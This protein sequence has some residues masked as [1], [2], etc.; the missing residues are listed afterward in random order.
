[1]KLRLL[2]LTLFAITSLQSYLAHAQKTQAQFQSQLTTHAERSQYKET[3]RYAEVISLCKQYQT[4]YPN[5][6]NCIQFGTTPEGRPMMALIAS[7]TGVLNAEQAKQ[8]KLPVVLIQGGIHAG[9]IDGK[10]AIF[11]AL[12]DTLEN[13]AAQGALEK[14]VVIFVPVFNVDGHER[15]GPWNRPNQRGPEQMGWRTTA[16]NFN[17]NRDYVKADAPEMQAMLKLVNT[18]D[19]L[20]VIDL[21]VTD[22]AKFEHDISIQVEPAIAGPEQIRQ[23]GQHLRDAVIADL[24]QQGSL[25][26]HFYMSFI[27]E[28]NPMSGFAD[29]VSTP[30][31]STGYFQLRNRLGMLVETHSWK[32]Y[33]TRVRITRNTIISVL[34]QLARHGKR[35]REVVLDQD[36]QASQQA[37]QLHTLTYKNTSQSRVIDFRGYAYTRTV[38]DISGALMTRYDENK[39]QIWRV[40][41]QEHV[42]P[43]LQVQLPLAGYIVPVA[44]AK[45]VAE[46]LHQ[47]GIVFEDISQ[48]QNKMELDTFRPTQITFST[49]SVEQHQTLKLVGN[50]KKELRTIPS[51]S[52]YVPIQ[53]SKA[54]L[55]ATLFEPQAEDA[56]VNWGWFNNAFEA[57][58]YM[59]AYVAE[60]VA[61]DMLAHHPNLKAEFNA[62]IAK[63]TRFANDP[64]ARLAF[65]AKRHSSW[66]DNYQLYPV[67][68]TDKKP[69]MYSSIKSNIKPNSKNQ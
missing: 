38:S 68:R 12:R 11:W 39:P 18:W 48:T 15:F 30:R 45:Q 59:E 66:D 10:D 49:K 41:L 5:F 31:F 43:D 21:H 37:G 50:W 47:H 65:F 27:E 14:Q 42:V 6:V 4:K 62:L 63:D 40:N 13:K 64:A 19:P 24:A 33:P 23:A 25:P 7:R 8:Q 1:M 36:K 34:D 52:L 2:S 44:Y 67:M 56:L 9:E 28:D 61:R 53:Q 3:G 17:L 20:A 58:E 54:K 46:K 51:G 26:Q 16:Q 29:N 57:K 55:I 60:D 69:N 22:G 32:D 35:W